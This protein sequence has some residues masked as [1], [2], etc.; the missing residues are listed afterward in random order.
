MLAKD[1]DLGR[2][3]PRYIEAMESMRKLVYGFYD[4]AFTRAGMSPAVWR[5]WRRRATAAGAVAEVTSDAVAHFA[6]PASEAW[7]TRFRQVLRPVGGGEP[8]VT[9][10]RLYWRQQK[11]RLRIVAQSAG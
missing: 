5:S 1:E 6:D 9:W 7:L 11:G 10:Q 4:D 3:G 8:V 2:H